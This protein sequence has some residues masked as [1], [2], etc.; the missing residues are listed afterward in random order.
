MA[1]TRIS[2]A[3]AFAKIARADADLSLLDVRSPSE[4]LLGSFDGAV[5]IP[6]LNDEHRHAV[7]LSYKLNGSES[8]VRLG[9]DLVDP[10]KASLQKRWHEAVAL[11]KG[12]NKEAPL[13]FCWRGGLRSQIACEWMREAG[14]KPLQVEGGFKALRAHAIETFSRPSNIVVV[15]GPTGSKKTQIIRA[16]AHMSVDLE[17]LARHRGS[18]FG[19]IIGVAQ[20]AQLGFENSLALRLEERQRCPSMRLV[21]EDES[22]GIGSRLIPDPFYAQMAIAPCVVVSEALSTRARWIYEDYVE[23]FLS[24]RDKEALSDPAQHFL[25]CLQKIQKKLG[26]L[27][28]QMISQ[29]IRSAFAEDSEEQ[30]IDWIKDLLIHYYD[31]QYEF[32]FQKKS[33]PMLFQGGVLEVIDFLNS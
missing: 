14:L 21:I 23:S 18:A 17:A 16:L 29:K 6:L 10:I 27:H 22:R 2:S 4:F 12:E 5:N 28:T 1:D 3:A 9:H 8:A 15:C 13:V 25:F 11:A 30:H 31:K 7:G 26:G 32:G 24:E 20:P 33:R 19:P